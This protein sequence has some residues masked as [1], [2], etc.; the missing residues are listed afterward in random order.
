MHAFKHCS[1]TKDSLPIFSFQSIS[2]LFSGLKIYFSL[3]GHV[4]FICLT[5]FLSSALSDF[6]VWQNKDVPLYV[7]QLPRLVKIDKNNLIISC[8]V[9]L[10]TR[11]LSARLRA[12]VIMFNTLV[13]PGKGLGGEQS[14]NRNK[15]AQWRI[16]LTRKEV[17]PLLLAPR[18]WP[19]GLWN[20][21]PYW[22]VFVAG[23]IW[24]PAIFQCDLR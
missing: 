17:W 21:L 14:K 24:P 3:G 5:E 12:W 15:A 18:S 13:K 8:S 1:F 23:G 20:V 2:A 10:R 19:L 7:L 9:L 6:W 4:L 16:N 11:D 22:K